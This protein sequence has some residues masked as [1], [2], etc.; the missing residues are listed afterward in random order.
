MSN[1]QTTI[2]ARTQDGEVTL[3]RHS[4]DSPI[5]PTAQIE[6]L[7][8]IRPDKVDWVFDQTQAEAEHRRQQE[9]RINIFVLIERLVGQFCG[10]LVAIAG[11]SAA[12][13]MAVNG[14]P[15]AGAFVGGT[16]LVA[17][18][19]AFIAGRG[20]ANVAKPKNGAGGAEAPGQ[21]AKKR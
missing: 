1:Q 3:S 15:W 21:K 20:V 2:Q 5:L 8:A 9:G 12:A 11:L 4:T 17:M 7:H 10:L 16:T 14:A 13:Y 18:V 19:T 6:R